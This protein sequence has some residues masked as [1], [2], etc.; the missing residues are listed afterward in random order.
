[1]VFELKNIY[2]DYLQGKEAVPVL[3]DIS[4]EVSEGGICGD[5]GSVRLGKVYAYEHYRMS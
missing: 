4:L 1:M 3:K 2:K 5:N